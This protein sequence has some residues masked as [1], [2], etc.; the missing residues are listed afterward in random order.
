MKLIIS[1]VEFQDPQ[2]PHVQSMFLSVEYK[3]I[4]RP[5]LPC[6][7]DTLST[8]DYNL[9]RGYSVAVDV[10]DDFIQLNRLV[11]VDLYGLFLSP[12]AKSEELVAAPI[13]NQKIDLLEVM[14]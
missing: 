5:I 6:R 12:K 11:S 9:S 1:N 2:I 10:P 8:L 3:D 14:N 7:V 4:Y 13:K